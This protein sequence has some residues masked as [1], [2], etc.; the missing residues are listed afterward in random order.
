MISD[1][2]FYHVNH[3]AYTGAGTPNSGVRVKG[4]TSESEVG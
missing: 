3:K 4:N 1:R 2:A